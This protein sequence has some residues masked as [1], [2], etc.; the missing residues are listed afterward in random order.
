V[1]PVDASFP[2]QFRLL[3]RSQFVSLAGSKTVVSGRLFLVIWKQNSV[4]RPR[5]GITASKKTGNAVVRN[6]MKRCVR[7]FFRLHRSILP[8]VDLNVIVR[9]QAAENTTAVLY[10]ELQRTFQQIGSC[11]CCH[12][13]L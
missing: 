12:E 13:S 10:E 2:K 5:L 4:G 9:R 3:Q 1:I 8:A 7:E 6:R 11:T